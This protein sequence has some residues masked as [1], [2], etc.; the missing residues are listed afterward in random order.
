LAPKHR[1]T[2]DIKLALKK[3]PH[4]VALWEY[5]IDRESDSKT[6]L[7]LTKKAITKNKASVNLWKIM[8]S[9]DKTALEKAVEMVPE[10]LEFWLAFAKNS[11]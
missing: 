5:V 6:K 10:C 4:S 9:L 11:D 2:E 3:M 1:V 8:I 7:E